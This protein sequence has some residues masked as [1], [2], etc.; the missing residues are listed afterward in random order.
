MFYYHPDHLGSTTLVTNSSRGIAEETSYRPFGE[1]LLD[2]KS[3]HLYTGKELDSESGLYYYGARYYNPVIGQFTQPD[4][5]IPNPYDPQSLNRYS[6]VLNNPYKYTDP[7]GH[8][9]ED[10]CV[11]EAIIAGAGIG[12]LFG[13][14]SSILTQLYF[15][16]KVD[17]AQ[18]G[19]STIVGGAAGGAG[20]AAAVYGV[21]AFGSSALASVGVG[22]SS[23]IVGG[24]VASAS[25]NVLNGE[26]FTKGLFNP[27]QMVGDGALGGI[28]GVIGYKL[29]GSKSSASVGGGQVTEENAASYWYKGD[30]FNS[31]QAS[32]DYHL[33]KHGSGLSS[34]EY[35][36]KAINLRTNYA[37]SGGKGYISKNVPL[38]NGRGSGQLIIDRNKGNVGLYTKKGEIVWYD[39]KKT[40]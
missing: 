37:S 28:A 5:I 36:S 25:S 12:A 4:T 17:L 14:G 29:S 20:A 21:I 11:G 3:K 16:G 6:Y 1:V 13:M 10:A 34:S 33:G 31:K 18:V 38:Q 8:C 2:G 32:L 23:G 22:A 24:Q 15:T 27:N 39:L 35:T 30:G 7:T 19:H 26:D 40:K 9:A